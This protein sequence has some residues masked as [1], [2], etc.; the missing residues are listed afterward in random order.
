DVVL[1]VAIHRFE[2]VYLADRWRRPDSEGELA[3]IAKAVFHRYF[4]MLVV[5]LT[6]ADFPVAGRTVVEVQFIAVVEKQFIETVSVVAHGFVIHHGKELAAFGNI[7]PVNRLFEDQ[8][9]VNAALELV[10]PAVKPAV[11]VEPVLGEYFN[12]DG[13]RG[14][15]GDI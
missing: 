12:T 5:A 14:E 15:D 9:A 7:E 3:R 10:H 6:Y 4:H 11:R 8:L 1:N 13:T 2:Q